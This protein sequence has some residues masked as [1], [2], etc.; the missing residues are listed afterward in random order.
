MNE[1]NPITNHTLLL[2]LETDE[3]NETVVVDMEKIYSDFFSFD[4]IG[5]RLVVA[6]HVIS[7]PFNITGQ[8]GVL[9]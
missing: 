5:K 1:T 4:S 9:W 3:S 7:I 6:F 2:P 8:I